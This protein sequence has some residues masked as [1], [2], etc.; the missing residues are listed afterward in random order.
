MP[1][2]FSPGSPATSPHGGFGSFQRQ[3]KALYERTSG[4]SNV[5]TISALDIDAF[6][7]SLG[8]PG[9][10]ADTFMSG[11]IGSGVYD[12]ANAGQNA[13]QWGAG[14]PRGVDARSTSSMHSCFPAAGP[15]HVVDGSQ[16]HQSD[17]GS[18]VPQSFGGSD[19]LDQRRASAWHDIKASFVV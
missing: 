11:G 13:G 10:G 16:W 1:S 8:H 2:A 15:G 12:A 5:S 14:P 17:T 6:C 18:L 4:D 19:P 3:P 9:A 7:S